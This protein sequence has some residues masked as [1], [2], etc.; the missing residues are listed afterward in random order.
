MGLYGQLWVALTAGDVPRDCLAIILTAPDD[1]VRNAVVYGDR[2]TDGRTFCY[3][4]RIST[5]VLWQCGVGWV[6]SFVCMHISYMSVS[7]SIMM[8]HVEQEKHFYG[9][10]LDNTPAWLFC[11]C[12]NA[13][14]TIRSIVVEQ[15]KKPHSSYRLQNRINIQSYSTFH[16]GWLS[17]CLARL[18]VL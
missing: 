2:P 7:E 16:F 12:C 13:N 17:S 14:D 8:Q 9:N 11:W 18:R 10:T 1:D 5:R 4:A 6:W 3:S 15:P